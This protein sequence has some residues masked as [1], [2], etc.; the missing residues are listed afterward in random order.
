MSPSPVP[1]KGSIGRTF[2]SG[3]STLCFSIQSHPATCF[4]EYSFIGTS[5]AHSFMCP[6]WWPYCPDCGHCGH[7]NLCGPS[8]KWVDP[9][10]TAYSH[11]DTT[12]EKGWATECK[13]GSQERQGVWLLWAILA[14]LCGWHLWLWLSALRWVWRLPWEWWV[15]STPGPT[16]PIQTGSRPWE[17][18]PVFVTSSFLVF[19]PILIDHIFHPFWERV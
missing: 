18:R 2:N 14:S 3:V 5:H 17:S 16:W 12:E 19:S 9:C 7:S 6:V 4:Y 15:Q 1:T 13:W 8:Q 10:S 11:R